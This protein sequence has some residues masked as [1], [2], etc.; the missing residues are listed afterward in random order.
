MQKVAVEQGLKAQV[1][2][3]KVA[4]GVQSR[5]QT[6]Q[7]ELLH[8]GVE[9]L[10]LYALFDELRKVLGIALGHLRL[11]QLFAQDLFADGMQQQAG[12]GAGVG[13][14]FLDQRAR[15]QDTGLV[16]LV[17]GHAVIQVAA[18]LGQ[19]GLWPHVGAQA[20]AGLGDQRAQA[21]QVQRHPL[22]AVGDMQLGLLRRSGLALAGTLLGAA[23]AVQHIGPRHFMVAATHQAQL[24]LV[25]HVFDVE[26]AATR[27]AAQQGTDH[28]FG[29]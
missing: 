13:R 2:E 7:V 26:G 16:H 8:P 19:D 1:V 9:Q 21:C 29:E 23:L 4:L 28:A 27:A 24:H 14:V 6:G 11:A 12:G 3:L 22:A 17:D 20:G 18:G 25:L 15:G 10:G 5:A